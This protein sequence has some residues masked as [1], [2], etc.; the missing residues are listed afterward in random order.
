M[1]KQYIKP[2]ITAFVLR[3]SPRL[4]CLSENGDTLRHYNRG[5]YDSGNIEEAV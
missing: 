4:I 5:N 3:R 2:T 1:K